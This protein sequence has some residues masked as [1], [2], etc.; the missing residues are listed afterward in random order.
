VFGDGA[1]YSSNPVLQ[2]ST[3][4]HYIGA[5]RM[6]QMLVDGASA[7]KIDANTVEEVARIVPIVEKFFSDQRIRALTAGLAEVFLQER[8]LSGDQIYAFLNEGWGECTRIAAEMEVENESGRRLKLRP[9]EWTK[10]WWCYDST[11]K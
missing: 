5:L 2:D 6:C 9:W 8:H 3:R 7:T 11:I 10:K 4:R 1:V